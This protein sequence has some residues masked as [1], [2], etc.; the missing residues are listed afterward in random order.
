MTQ[1]TGWPDGPDVLHLARRSD[2]CTVLGPGTRAVLWVQGCPLRCPGCVAAETLPFAGGTAVAVA[3]LARELAALP[4][5]EGVTLSGG[6]PT[7]QSAALCN[8][9][10]RTRALRDLSFLSYSGFTLEHL[11]R[12]GTPAQ[13]ELLRR[14]DVLIDGPYV[15]ARHTDLRWRGSDNQRVHFLSDRYRH[16]ADAVWERGTWLEAEQGPDGSVQWVGIPPPGFR[17]AFERQ[18]SAIGIHLL[19]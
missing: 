6:E 7:S 14:L 1:S 19:K 9:I 17:A 3:D 18:L 15:E 5:V 11:R 16:L 8:L 4:D 10:D 12:R 13:H 2:R